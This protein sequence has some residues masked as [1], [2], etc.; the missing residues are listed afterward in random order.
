MSGCLV[1]WHAEMAVSV[2]PWLCAV[3]LHLEICLCVEIASSCG[4]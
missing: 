4:C 1:G 3:F 2:L